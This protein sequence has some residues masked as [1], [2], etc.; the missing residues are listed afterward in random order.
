MQNEGMYLHR[1]TKERESSPEEGSEDGIGCHGRGGVDGEAGRNFISNLTSAD[2]LSS[3][4][5]GDLRIDQIR[6][7]AHKGRYEPDADEERA[8]EWD[9][10]LDLVE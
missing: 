5:G 7:D 4:G 9:S 3:Y 2:D 6:V 10:P 1:Q 8:E